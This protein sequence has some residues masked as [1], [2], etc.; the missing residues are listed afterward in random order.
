MSPA[1]PR[2]GTP[3]CFPVACACARSGVVLVLELCSF[4]ITHTHTHTHT[5]YDL[6]PRQHSTML[7][8]LLCLSL[9]QSYCGKRNIAT[10]NG[11]VQQRYRVTSKLHPRESK[12]PGS[13]CATWPRALSAR[14]SFESIGTASGTAVPQSAKFTCRD[15]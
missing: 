15:Y 10:L 4:F 1:V 13:Q 11:A 2:F 8:D 7:S 9:N 14:H 5:Q 3:R 12:E 6:I